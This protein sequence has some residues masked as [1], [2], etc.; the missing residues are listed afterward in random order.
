MRIN[1][2]ALHNEQLKQESLINIMVYQIWFWQNTS[3]EGGPMMVYQ[4]T[5]LS[6]TLGHEHETHG[7]NSLLQFCRTFACPVRINQNVLQIEQL[8]Q[9]SYVIL[10]IHKIWFWHNSFKEG[11]PWWSVR[12]AMYHACKDMGT[13]PGE[14]RA[15]RNFAGD[16]HV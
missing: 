4:R 8:K 5:N 10:M 15:I 11:K 2:Y 16:L 7:G 1:H 14:E 9:E 12:G 6:S 13:K 3:K